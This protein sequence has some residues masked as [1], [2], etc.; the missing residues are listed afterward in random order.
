MERQSLTGDKPGAGHPA[1]GRVQLQL[2]AR[3]PAQLLAIVADAFDIRPGDLIGDT[4]GCAKVA[5]ARQTGMYLARVCLGLTLS[6]AASL[7]GR[8]RTT[9]AHACRV[10][11]DRRDDRGFDERLDAI[12]KL[13]V[14]ATKV[15]PR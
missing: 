12:E 3:L 8:D 9:A 11:E 7:F 4:R 13:L 14:P 5:L 15:R 6:Q 2:S 1:P 10:I